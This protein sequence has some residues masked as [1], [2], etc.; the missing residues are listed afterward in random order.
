M[1]GLV[2]IYVSVPQLRDVC[3]LYTPFYLMAI[4]L[5][6]KNDEFTQQDGFSGMEC[7]VLS[8]AKYL[9]MLPYWKWVK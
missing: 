4:L 5:K 8:G 1:D 7:H 9:E 3:V 6:T 2:I